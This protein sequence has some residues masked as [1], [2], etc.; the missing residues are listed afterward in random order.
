M[1]HKKC[2]EKTRSTGLCFRRVPF[3]AVVFHFGL[4][5]CGQSH[6][7]V[8]DMQPQANLAGPPC[9]E[10]DWIYVP[11]VNV[12]TKIGVDEP[13]DMHIETA[14]LMGDQYDPP[15]AFSQSTILKFENIGVHTLFVRT[16]GPECAP[17]VTRRV[18]EVT[19]GFP[20]MNGVDKDSPHI[21][22]WASGW[23]EP[24]EYGESVVDNWRTPE[25]AMG[26]ATGQP[27]DIVSLGRGGK[28]ELFFDGSIYNGEGVDFAIFEN[29]FSET[30]LELALVEV[31]SDEMN[32]VQ[33]P[34]IYM[35]TDEIHPYG[36]HDPV[37]FYGF[38]GRY[39]AGVGTP[40]DLEDL[41]FE[42]A[43]IDGSVDLDRITSIRITDVIGDGSTLDSLGRPIFDPFPTDGSAGFDLDAVGVMYL[44]ENQA[45]AD[46][47]TIP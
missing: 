32:Y 46:S 24:V 25:R 37:L 5:A 42:A 16:T 40:F 45:L 14:I 12:G 26:P 41:R 33:F 7:D 36:D 44:N 27:A 23:S 35:G 2:N 17:T 21:R 39:P 47:E 19:D 28:I 18:I 8:A 11:F 9:P 22:G 1:K 15:S 3:L 13:E 20:S 43:V 31:S 4:V 10:A 29:S 6:S 34:V 30:F 38:A